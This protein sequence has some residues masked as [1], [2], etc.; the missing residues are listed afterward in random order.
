MGKFV[1]GQE[2]DLSPREIKE[3][4]EIEEFTQEANT[5]FNKR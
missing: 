3:L 2:R 4:S 5:H 1:V